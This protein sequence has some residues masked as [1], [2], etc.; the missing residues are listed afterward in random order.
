ML[1]KA[2]RKYGVSE[3]MHYTDGLK[4]CLEHVLEW[5]A[6][7]SESWTASGACPLSAAVYHNDGQHH[8]EDP[9]G[10]RSEAATC[11]R[12]SNKDALK[13]RRWGNSKPVVRPAKQVWMQMNMIKTDVMRVSRGVRGKLDTEINWVQLNQTDLF[14]YLSGWVTENSE[15]ECEIQSRLGSNERMWNNISGFVHD[16]HM[17]LRLKAHLYSTMVHSTMLYGTEA[18]VIKKQQVQH[19]QVFKMQSLHYKRSSTKR[20]ILKLKH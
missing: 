16:W 18:W 8:Q 10:K 3:Q 5:Q 7:W 13:R 17:P 14:K 15:L 11:R 4:Q 19:L 20:N 6:L 1:I 12:H 2:L 9:N